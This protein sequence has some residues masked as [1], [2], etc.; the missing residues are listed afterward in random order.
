MTVVAWDGET[1]AVDCQATRGYVKEKSKKG[2]YALNPKP[3]PPREKRLCII[4]AVG[5]RKHTLLMKNH[6]V[7]NG[8]SESIRDL[9]IPDDTES[10]YLVIVT[11]KGLYIYS[12]NGL[13]E[14]YGIVPT[15]FGCG[16]ECAMGAMHAGADAKKAVEITNQ[17]ITGCGMGVETF[18]LE[19][20]KRK[21]A[22]LMRGRE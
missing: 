18:T 16:K 17:L 4:A 7:E 19:E 20:G 5:C 8:F 3:R 6:F 22:H 21:L 14:E 10:S 9:G 11:N 15:A 1:L 13:W 2:W 12:P